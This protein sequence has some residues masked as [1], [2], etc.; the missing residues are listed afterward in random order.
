M[1]EGYTARKICNEHVNE[2][3][4]LYRNT[5]SSYPSP[6]LDIEYVHNVMQTHV[7]F[8]GVF[9]GDILVS[10]ASAEVD[11]RNRNSEITDCATLPEHRG[12]GLLSN[13]IMLLEKEMWVQKIAALYSLARAGSYGMNAALCRLGYEYKGR[14]INNCHIGGRY[15][16]MNLWVKNIKI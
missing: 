1:P 11:H 3:V 9:V 10:A 2:L 6:L 14:F 4:E 15:E 5:F 12:K 13:L 7:T 8:Y 16:D